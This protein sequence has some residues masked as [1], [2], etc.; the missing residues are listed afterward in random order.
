MQHSR[1]YTDLTDAEWA[2]LEPY[3]PPA[4]LR[5]RPMLHSRRTIVNAIF[6]LI[7]SGCAWRLLPKDLPPWQTVYHYWRRWRLDGTWHRLNT[8]L[9]ERVRRRVGRNAQP[10]AGIIDSQ[11]V[12]TTSVGGVRG[13]DGGKKISGRKRHLLVDTLG[14]GLRA[15][16]HAADLQDRAAVP[17]LLAGASTEYPRME[18]VWVDRGYTGTG[19]QW[20]HEQLGWQVEIVH[21]P[22]RS[23]RA[24]Q[25]VPDP[26]DP[27]TL[28]F[29][30]VKV[31]RTE[32]GF[33]GVLPRRWVVERSF[34]WLGHSR[35]L[36]K[37]YER[38]CETSE[39]LMY[40]AMS[41]IMVRRLAR[42]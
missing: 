23:G 37:H 13:Y 36:S 40:A 29:R 25:W 31:A 35:R 33:R 1:Y 17:L 24:W 19:A 5:G 15:N 41:R 20:I 42:T 22:P 2:I 38:L 11:S 39:A 27:M 34:A 9:R 4:A 32:T 26:D 7:R 10:S 18:L 30:W 16:V 12:K 6:Y 28:R 14:L 3:L 21:H 8:A